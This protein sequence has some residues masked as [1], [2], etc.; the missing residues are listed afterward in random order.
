MVA[1]GLRGGLRVAPKEGD[2]W[3]DGIG[4]WRERGLA[5]EGPE[6]WLLCFVEA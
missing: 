5:W 6:G 3:G 1:M 2:G 4:T